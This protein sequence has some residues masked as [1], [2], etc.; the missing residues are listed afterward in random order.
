MHMRAAMAA[1]VALVAGLIAG[2]AL[3]PAAA[4]GTAGQGSSGTAGQDPGA[5]GAGS[6][7]TTH[8]GSPVTDLVQSG[9]LPGGLLAEP[10]SPISGYDGS[11]P[12]DCQLQQ[13]GTGTDFPDPD[14]DPFCVEYDKTNQNVTGLGIVDFLS[15][16]PA[17]V[18][19][20]VDKC[21]YYQRDHWHAAVHQPWEET[22]IYNWDGG[23]FF[24][25]A[26]GAFGVYV[27]NLTINNTSVDP[28]GL[29]GF[30]SE[31][32]P[33]FGYGQGGVQVRGEIPVDPRC[34]QAAADQD[35]YAEGQ[36]AG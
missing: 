24:D 30:P 7:G 3:A 10:P 15:N 31:W 12:F 22:E 17:R 36:G 11:N 20:A 21:F 1:V 4:A 27:E 32:E 33:Y 29:P 28:T 18:A 16:E 26:R 14:A 25:K 8:A 19:A 5:V 35:P 23:Y 6:P 13:V 2:A 34:V 9:A